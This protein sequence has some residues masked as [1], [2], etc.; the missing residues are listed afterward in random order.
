MVTTICLLTCALATGQANDRPNWLLSPRLTGGQEL[1]YRGTIQEDNLTRGVQFSRA[2][3]LES[4]VFVLESSQRG[5]EVALLTVLKMR[6]LNS[7][8]GKEAD[9]SSVRLEVVRADLQ[10]RL[11]PEPGA[12]FAVVL[13]GPTTVETGALFDIP[14]L[15]LAVGQTWEQPEA[16]RPTRKWKVVGSETISGSICHRLEGLQQSED[17]DDPRADKTAWRRRDVV[18][19]SARLGV[20][21]RVER[22]IERREPARLEPTQ[23]SMTRFELESS[24]QY[25]GQLFDDRRREIVMA[26]SFADS[27]APLLPTPGK[28]SPQVFDTLLKKI[29]GHMQKSAPTPYRDAIQLVRRRVEAARRGESPPQLQQRDDAIVQVRATIDQKVPDFVASNLLTRESVRLHRLLGKPVLL[30][31]YTP[32]SNSAA[33][34]LRFTQQMAEVHGDKVSIAALSLSDDVDL[35]RKQQTELG[36]T[37]PILAGKGM[38]QS[39]A[40]EATPRLLVIDSAG[41]VRAGFEGWG[42]ETAGGTAAELKRLLANSGSG[43]APRPRE[44]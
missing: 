41:Y 11:I 33:E 17:W 13:D 25:P 38:R 21:Y 19:L 35:L 37:F 27:A 12:N 18:W 28:Y 14:R 8:P 43:A 30:V 24:L 10:G 6:G 9:P 3:R 44:P 4:R 22:T 32:N 34:V 36:L 2:Y 42:P 39:F 20:A 1:V 23:K 31:F 15:R 40:V 29:D 7:E 5:L 26:R 16:G